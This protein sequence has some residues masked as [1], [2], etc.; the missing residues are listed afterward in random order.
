MKRIDLKRNKELLG[1][2]MK[3][4]ILNGN[5]NILERKC[6]LMM[7]WVTIFIIANTLNKIERIK[8]GQDLMIFI[9]NNCLLR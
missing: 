2:T 3:N 8:I 6:V 7:V 5:P 4:S 9:V 1:G